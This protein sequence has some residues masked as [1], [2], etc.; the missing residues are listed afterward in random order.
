MVAGL[1]LL[2]LGP[3]LV[4]GP[5]RGLPGGVIAIWVSGLGDAVATLSFYAGRFWFLRKSW[6][7]RVVLIAL[8]WLVHISLEI[9]ICK[10]GYC[11]RSLRLRSARTSMIVLAGGCF[12]LLVWLP[13]GGCTLRGPRDEIRERLDEQVSAWNRGDVDGFMALYWNSPSLAF[14]VY[15]RA[16]SGSPTSQPSITRGWQPVRDRYKR[17]YPTAAE[18]GQLRFQKVDVNMTGRE[19]ATAIGQY[20]MYRDHKMFSWGRFELDIIKLDGQ[21]M[22]IRDRTYP[23]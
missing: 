9:L 10:S 5:R 23:G 17:R 20:E 13:S 18:M 6:S 11:I 14:E 7:S 19:R 8:S 4:D 22:I 1:A 15:P 12:A 21:W 16:P 3:F 2:M